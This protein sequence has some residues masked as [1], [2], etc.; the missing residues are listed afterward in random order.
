MTKAFSMSVFHF[1]DMR[2]RS[3]PLAWLNIE[4]WCIFSICMLKYPCSCASLAQPLAQS[5]SQSGPPPEKRWHAYSEDGAFSVHQDHKELSH[6]KSKAV[7]LPQIYTNHRSMSI[8][9]LLWIWGWQTCMLCQSKWHNRN[10]CFSNWSTLEILQKSSPSQE[11]VQQNKEPAIIL[12]QSHHSFQTS[13]GLWLVRTMFPFC[14][15][16]PQVPLGWMLAVYSTP[17]SNRSP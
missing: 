4:F 11:L 2:S 14:F 5:W 10:F 13:T 8:T 16:S 6:V 12:Q 17:L 3:F 15:W 7:V 1:P 9:S